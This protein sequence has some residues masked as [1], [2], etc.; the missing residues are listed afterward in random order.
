[1]RRCATNAAT[2]NPA[3]TTARNGGR[4][5]RRSVGTLSECW[6]WVRISRAASRKHGPAKQ[7]GLNSQ[8]KSCGRIDGSPIRRFVWRTDRSSTLGTA[9]ARAFSVTLTKAQVRHVR[10]MREHTRDRLKFELESASRR[11]SMTRRGSAE[12]VRST[13]HAFDQWAAAEDPTPHRR[14]TLFTKDWWACA[15]WVYR[16]YGRRDP[17]ADIARD[18]DQVAGAPTSWSEPSYVSRKQLA[19]VRAGRLSSWRA[20]RHVAVQS[21]AMGRRPGRSA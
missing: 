6:G 3:C 8:R 13:M 19:F 16:H 21:P 18:N 1:M 9:G 2:T 17:I 4:A 12:Q 7:A 11:L 20:P 5:L 10:G 14:K 15:S